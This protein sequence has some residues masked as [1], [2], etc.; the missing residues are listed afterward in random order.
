MYLSLYCKGSKEVTQGFMVRGSWRPNRT[1][2]FWSSLLWLS[3]LCLS[4]SP[5]LLNRKPRGPLCWVMAFFTASYQQLLWTP[6]HQGTRG[7]LRPF[8]AFPTTT[9]Q[10]LFSNCYSKWLTSVLTELYSSLTPTQSPTNL[11]NGM[12]ARHQAEITVM[13]FT[14]HSLLVHHSVVAQWDLH[15]VPY[16]QS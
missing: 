2:I 3:A 11:W 15:F 10:Q 14:G 13:Q 12:F 5:G 16:Y 6:T 9:Y 7:P 1:A 4:R 8:V